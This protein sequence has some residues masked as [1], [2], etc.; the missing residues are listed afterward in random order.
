[1]KAERQFLHLS[2]Q[3]AFDFRKRNVLQDNLG[4]YLQGQ[5]KHTQIY[6]DYELQL[7]RAA[8]LRKQS[9]QNLDQ[10]LMEFEQKITQNGAKVIWVEN[11]KEAQQQTLKIIQERNQ[12]RVIQSQSTICQEINLEAFLKSNEIQVLQSSISE[13]IASFSSQKSGHLVDPLSHLSS[14]EILEIIKKEIDHQTIGEPE[15]LLNQLSEIVKKQFKDIKIGISGANFLLADTGG[16]AISE[17]EGNI[18]LINSLCDTHIVVAGID[19]ILAKTTDLDIFWTQYL[20][21]TATGQP[22]TSL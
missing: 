5:Q 16:I 7:S 15:V 3:I 8:Y 12:S 6:A 13:Y 1:M 17:N 2:E 19:K 21:S 14:K 10:Y 11:A 9:I 20:L 18:R 22:L 4:L